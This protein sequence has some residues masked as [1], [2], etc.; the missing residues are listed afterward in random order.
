MLCLTRKPLETIHI[1]DHIVVTICET[2]R[3]GCKVG[4]DAPRDVRITRG[5]LVNDTNQPPRLAEVRRSTLGTG[6]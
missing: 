5:E 2:S 1:G 4:I 6:S 3:G